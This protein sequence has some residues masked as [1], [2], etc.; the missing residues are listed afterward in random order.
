MLMYHSRVLRISV[1]A[2]VSVWFTLVVPAH[3]R[4]T[5]HLPGRDSAAGA[6]GDSCGSCC[7]KTATPAQDTDSDHPRRP[8]DPVRCC[9]V[10]QLA[11]KLSQDAGV[12]P[13]LLC[14]GL[15]PERA[16]ESSGLGAATRSIVLSRPRAPPRSV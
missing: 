14:A 12:A 4:G 16:I 2:F 13:P 10:C 15:C 8:T 3:S 1:L 6:A 9:A 5:V 11:M 7:P